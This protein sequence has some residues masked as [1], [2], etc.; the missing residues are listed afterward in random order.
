PGLPYKAIVL[1][2]GA[3]TIPQ[4]SNSFNQTV[5]GFFQASSAS[6]QAKI[7]YIVGD[8]QSFNDQLVFNGSSLGSNVFQGAQGPMWDN[9]TFDVSALVPPNA[10]QVTTS[11]LQIEDCLTWAAVVFSITVQDTD[12]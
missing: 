5:L 2:D 8:G 9:A 3:F 6:P 1:D 11:S 12:G 10:S 7:T 4:S